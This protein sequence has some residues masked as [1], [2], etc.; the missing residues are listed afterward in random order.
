MYA[1]DVGINAGAIWS[2]L[3][4]KGKL[5]IREIGELTNFREQFI[6]LAFGWLLREDKIRFF[7]EKGVVYVEL[8]QLATEM[9]F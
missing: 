8:K 1:N 7:E 6:Y 5:S 4:E 3:S 9:Y 2:L